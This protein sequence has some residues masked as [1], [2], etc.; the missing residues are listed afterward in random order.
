VKGL[1]D[2]FFAIRIPVGRGEAV[3]LGLVPVVL[4]LAIWTAATRG[5]PEDRPGGLL[6]PQPEEVAKAGWKLLAKQDPTR[7]VYS[8]AIDSLRRVAFGFL[9]AAAVCVPLG[10]AMGAFSRVGAVFEPMMTFLGY[11]PI[12]ALVPLTLLWFG[13]GEPQK[14][15]FL[16]IAGI[17]YMLPLVVRSVTQVDDV[18]LQTAYTLGARKRHIVTKVLM[19][20]AAADA[21]DALRLAFGVGWTYI[22]L[23]EMVLAESGIGKMIETARGR[24][25]RPDIVY[26]LVLL[27]VAIGFAI[28]KAFAWTGRQL[29]PYRT[30][31]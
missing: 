23:A 4:G 17:C 10:V 11:L 15:A 6:L 3:L 28:D 25:N 29:F 26:F 22:M 1:I 2:R 18:F 7:N 20:V 16:G 8:D 24:S 12:A 14:V 13:A 31:R 30:A 21:F 9:L 5:E 27:I 19:P